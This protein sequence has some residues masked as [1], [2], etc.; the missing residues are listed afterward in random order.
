MVE[1]FTYLGTTLSKSIVLD[2]DVNSRLAKARSTF[3][4][5][6]RNVWNRRG[7]SEAT[8]IKVY[9]AVLLT[10]LFYDCETWTTYQRHIKNL[11]HFH[12]TCL[13]KIHGITWQ[14]HIPDT[15]DL[16][17][18]SL[19]SIFIIVMQSQVRWAGYVVRMKDHRLP[20]K[21]LYGELSQGKCSQGG[22]KKRFKDS[23]KV[24][25]KSIGVTPSCLEYLAVDRDKRHEIIKR[26]A[27]V[28]ETRS[29]AATELRRKH[30]KG[31]AT[32]ANATTIPWSHC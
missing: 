30:R 32:S 17:R 10:T 26:G 18:A 4:R 28:C 14:K 11:Q 22:Q 15:E 24:S 31:T 1:K 13:R 6:N 21:L 19:P 29:N 12:M 7:I 27:K 20:K 9:R 2:D 3:G 16:T 23:L 8:K 25:L 5:L